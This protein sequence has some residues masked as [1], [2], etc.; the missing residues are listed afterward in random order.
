M[1]LLKTII[2]CDECQ[3]PYYKALWEPEWLAKLAAKELH[4][5]WH[6]MVM[7]PET[8]PLAIEWRKWERERIIK[9]LEEQLAAHTLPNGTV[10]IEFQVISDLIALIKGEQK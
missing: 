1:K 6:E 8:T 9:L 3:M 10:Y 5:E 4:L 2:I 7:N